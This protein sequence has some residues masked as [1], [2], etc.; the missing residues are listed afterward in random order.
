[1][2]IDSH[3]HLNFSDF[4]R[5][6]QLIIE[7][8]LKNNIWMI[9]VGVNFLSSKKAVEL[10]EKHGKGIYASIGLYPENIENGKKGEHEDSSE[11]K[12]ENDFDFEKY[13]SLSKS[14]KVVAVGEVGLDYWHKPKGKEKRKLFKQKQKEVLIRQLDFASYF[15]Y[16]IIF[17]CRMAHNDLLEIIG[18]Y[19]KEKKRLKGVIHSFVG[20]PEE[21]KKYLSLGLFVGF[22]GMIFKKIEGINFNNLIKTVPFEK[23]LIETDSPF[24]KPPQVKIKKN[25]KSE[26]DWRNE[27]ANVYYVAQEIARIKNAGLEE[28]KKRTSQN[29]IGLF[30]LT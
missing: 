6:R 17:H 19:F 13:S 7:K 26:N 8:N 15:N 25:E 22:N 1:M 16:P 23:I 29:A 9:N 14:K 4:D 12:K 27:P 18:N 24:L 11:S 5:D 28:V 21:M 30:S 3:C 2:L 20:N 10:A